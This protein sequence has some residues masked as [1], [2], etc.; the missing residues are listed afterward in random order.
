M[1]KIAQVLIGAIAFR[2]GNSY[3]EEDNQLIESEPEMEPKIVIQNAYSSLRSAIQSA[4]SNGEVEGDKR[5]D[6]LNAYN[7]LVEIERHVLA[8]ENNK[9][10]GAYSDY[11]R[12]ILPKPANLPE[13]IENI[14]TA[15]KN[16]LNVLE[17]YTETHPN[18]EPSQRTWNWDKE[19]RAYPRP[20]QL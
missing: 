19:L 4:A 11:S 2:A 15:S 18:L 5:T 3:R 9:T 14:L 20:P 8:L 10:L 1:H 12:E 13:A 16:M 7:I 17:E 6:L